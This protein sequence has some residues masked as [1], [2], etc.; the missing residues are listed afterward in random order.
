MSSV[1]IPMS[2][3]AKV[4]N[5]S[6]LNSERNY[7]NYLGSNR[8]Y[9]GQGDFKH[10][11]NYIK[12]ISKGGMI[13]ATKFY[14]FFAR[15]I[16]GDQ[17][18]KKNKDLAMQINDLDAAS[19]PIIKTPNKDIYVPGCTAIQESGMLEKLFGNLYYLKT[20]PAQAAAAQ[21]AA[22]AGGS[23]KETWGGK[24]RRSTKKRKSKR[25]HKRGRHTKRI[26]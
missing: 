6:D 24:K 23:R 16:Q 13:G 7:Y 14:I 4:Q 19:T 8:S 9:S 17:E 18:S 15:G 25:S 5:A 20:A 10:L 2:D 22:A 11:G 12:T 3:V 1:N 21:A 26:R